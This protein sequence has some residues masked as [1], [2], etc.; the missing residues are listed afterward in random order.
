MNLPLAGYKTYITAALMF[1]VGV[2]E[3]AG[4][5]VPGFSGD[6][7]SL[8]VGAMGLIFARIGAANAAKASIIVLGLMLVSSSGQAANLAPPALKAPVAVPCTVT[9]CTG[10]F[11]GGFIANAGGN[12]DVIGTGLTGLAQNGI[13][14][15]GQAGYEYFANNVYAALYVDLQDDMNL[16][17][18]PGTSLAS[19]LTYG[20]T[21]RLGYSLASAFGAATTSTATP[22]LPQQFMASLMTPYVNAGEVK[23]HGQDALRS[24][25]GVEALL[26]TNVTL[27]ADYFHY[28]FN[29]GGSAGTLAGMPVSLASDNEFRLSINRH[30][31]F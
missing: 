11:V 15:G 25:V 30:F 20:V 5:S 1:I 24:G 21:A 29:Q 23:R 22:T 26:S 12:L 27:N 17:A 3:A 10:L 18:P 6:P 8:I 2:A 9:S 28:T 4:V 7:G 16:S 14:F 13:G 19:K 31:G